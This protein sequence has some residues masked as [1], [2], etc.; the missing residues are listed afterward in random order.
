MVRKLMK[1]LFPR[2]KLTISSNMLPGVE[3]YGGKTGPEGLIL[4]CENDWADGCGKIKLTIHD[5]AGGQTI[6]QYYDPDTLFRDFE[7]KVQRQE[8]EP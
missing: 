8:V 7:M 5:G 2:V 3:I 1:R 4:L 6:T